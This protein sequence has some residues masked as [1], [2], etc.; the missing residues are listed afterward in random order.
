VV[1]PVF[2][3]VCNCFR[4]SSIDRFLT[5]SELIVSPAGLFQWKECSTITEPV[6]LFSSFAFEKESQKQNQCTDQKG[7]SMCNIF[8][9]KKYVADIFSLLK[10][11]SRLFFFIYQKM[12]CFLYFKT[13]LR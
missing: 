4:D 6:V 5:V 11:I 12:F 1:N 13:I 8:A 7:Q 2:G 3:A 10:P 9:G